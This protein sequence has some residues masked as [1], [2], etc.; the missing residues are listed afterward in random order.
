MASAAGVRRSTS[1]SLAKRHASASENIGKSTSSSAAAKKR[2]ALANV[3][4]QRHGSGSFNSGRVSAP[5]SSKIVRAN[6][7][8][9]YFF[10]QFFFTSE[11]GFWCFCWCCL[12]TIF[13]RCCAIRGFSMWFLLHQARL[14]VSTS[15]TIVES[16]V[17]GFLGRNLLAVWSFLGLIWWVSC[18]NIRF[19]GVL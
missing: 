8:V 17:H 2:P 7:W 10:F 5:E 15:V 13:G 9:R 4:N 14:I 11:F 6:S 19:R 1:S 12:C 18:L 3:T 16:Y